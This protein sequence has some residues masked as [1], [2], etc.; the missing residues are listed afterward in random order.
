M[1]AIG[2]AALSP[3]RRVLESLTGG[4]TNYEHEYDEFPGGGQ[5]DGR[6]K[7]TYRQDGSKQSSG[8]MPVL[9]RTIPI[10]V[11]ILLFGPMDAFDPEYPCF[12][13]SCRYVHNTT[14]NLAGDPNIRQT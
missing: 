14:D 10:G 5:E 12:D 11:R 8:F 2:A 6:C 7:Y 1:C 3:S 9:G 4:M 13:S